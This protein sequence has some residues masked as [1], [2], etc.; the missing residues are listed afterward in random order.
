MNS[1]KAEQQ[2]NISKFYS[3]LKIIKLLCGCGSANNSWRKFS[4]IITFA[5]T[6][7]ILLTTAKTASGQTALTGITTHREDAPVTIYTTGTYTNPTPAD[8]N[9]TWGGT[10]GNL[11]LD[12]VTLSGKSLAAT[13]FADQ[14]NLVRVDNSFH[15]GNVNF[16]WAEDANPATSGAPYNF[17]PEYPGN[18]MEDALLGRT[19]NVGSD[20]IFV[21]DEE[22]GGNNIERIDYIFS[23][24]IQVLSPDNQGFIVLER[25]GN[26]GFKM[27]GIESISG[28]TPAT[29]GSNLVTS[30]AWGGGIPVDTDTLKDPDSGALNRLPYREDVNGQSIRGVF[31]TFAE[32][33]FTAGDTVYGYSL[34]GEDANR[35]CLENPT[36]CPQ[37]TASADGGMDF[38]SGGGMLSVADFG[39]APD[40]Y[41]TDSRDD[42]GEGFGASHTISNQ[43][44]LGST[45]PDSEIDAQTPLDG[46]GDG[47][48][49]DGISNF[50]DLNTSTNSY[51][52]EVA[53]NNTSGRAGNVYGWIDFDRDGEFDEDERATVSDGT[54]ALDANGQ[55]SSGS[56][57]TVTL[58]WNN[59]GSTTGADITDGNSYARIRFTSEEIDRT[60]ETTGRD[61]ASIGIAGDGEV[62]DYQI[63]ISKAF[64]FGDAPD[65]YGDVSHE[66]PASPSVYLGSVEPDN[67]ADT[68]LGSNAGAA[69]EGDDNDGNDDEDAFANLPNVPATGSYSIDVPLS[70]AGNATLHGWIDLN[71]DGKFEADE[72]RN[73][74]VTSTDTEGTLT[75]NI[76]AAVP[77]DSFVRLRLTSDTLTDES[78]TDIDERSV[79]SAND[80]EVEDYPVTIEAAR[81]YDYGDAPDT[82]AGTGTG[83]YQTTST[84]GGAAQVVL[85]E[86]NQVLS[87]GS[88][89]DVDDGSLQDEDALADDNDG[90]PDD[91]DGVS[92]FPTLTTAEGQTYTVSVTAKNNVPG[93]APANDAY[94][95]GFIDFNKD[96]DFLDDG[97]QSA[98]VTIPSDANP[99]GTSGALRTFDV[100]FT[101]PAGMTAGDTYARF[102]LGQVEATAESATG[103]PESTGT[104]DNG[105]IEDYKIAIASNDGNRPLGFPFTCD[106]TFY[107]TIGNGGNP[108]APQF[109]YDVNRSGDTY[110]FVQRGPETSDTNG[111]PTTFRYNALAYNPVDNYLY[112]IVQVSNA[113][114]GPYAPRNVVKIGSDGILRSIGIPEDSSG[115]P[116]PRSYIAA[117]ILSDGTYVVSSNSG[118]NSNFAKL[119]VTTSPPTILSTGSIS[120][121]NFT[122]FAVDPTDPTSLSG[123]RVYGIDQTSNTLVIL[124]LTNENPVI[125][126]RATNSTGFTHNTGSQFVD[127]FGTL[128][129]RS[130]STNSLYRV[131][132]DPNSSTYGVATEITTAPSGGNH[133][134]ASCL[135]ASAMQKEVQDLNGNSI[136]TSPAGETVNYIYTIASGNTQNLTNVIFEDDL[137]SVANGNPINSSFT[138]NF[139]VSNGS[140]TVSFS[141]SNQTLQ[142]RDLI[143]PAQTQTTTDADKLTIT[144]EV[145]ISDTLSPGEY[146]NQ[147]TI[148]NLPPQYPATIPSDYPTSPAYEDPT[149]LQVTEP[150]ASDPNLLLV[151]RITA[152]NPGKTNETQFNEFVDDPGDADNNSNWPDSD[153]DA[154]NNVNDY[155]RGAI[156]VADIQPGDEVEYTIYFLSNGDAEARSVKICDVIP[157][158]MS[159]VN[160][161]YDFETGM[162]LGLSSATLPPT[163]V[164]LTNA[165]DTDA[166]TFYAPGTAPPQVGNPPAN[167]CRKVDSAGNTVE[168]DGTNN[169]NGAVVVEIDNL[170]EATSPGNPAN[171]YGFIR[172]R[173]RVQ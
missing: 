111:Y 119:D 97:E 67:E 77:G 109:L 159:F 157:D 117:S 110:T 35:T 170:P 98:T 127:S 149:P 44:Y 43:I 132:S 88:E 148:R 108:P 102:R 36:T 28:S 173:A 135:F 53:V 42:S 25:G 71:G 106:S 126:D 113:T 51:S 72:Y 68:Q 146:F 26:D 161:S 48:D 18:N 7:I 30:T 130:N 86:A 40:T 38:I 89:I 95:V 163:P 139:T 9:Y 99:T 131:D 80:G 107:I 147:S 133:D 94:L 78:G 41:G 2:S 73:D 85:D 27:A 69:A 134:G 145:Q 138:G 29:Y 164:D 60:I 75:W 143:V 16:I 168:V 100:I 47:T 156:N 105:E 83:N 39:D 12:G 3:Q 64:D 24:G 56:S 87:L 104:P 20:N 45:L 144:A 84:N 1:S 61:D 58:N 162:A 74:S 23:D 14:I 124:D 96:G 55:V 122:D 37:T 22:S 52:L 65:A 167:L 160:N 116:L 121:A 33:G 172:F 8:K 136:T 92:S 165:A 63:A 46:T 5:W 11:I 31:I 128:Y 114:T 90:T 150:I 54:V 118:A 169:V 57:G 123:G 137:R 17:A 154:S 21:N 141:N 152:I 115:N 125:V 103:A 158:N 91:E 62:E 82:G 59:L 50:T 10:N 93:V 151:K 79:G 166:G 81:I 66:I 70:T 142:I 34:V 15:T 112:A 171:S 13:A 129:Y 101:T 19:I 32:L 6:N 49:E 153:G 76:T 4:L 120:G 155:L 140:G